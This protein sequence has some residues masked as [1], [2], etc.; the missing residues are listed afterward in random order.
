MY[1]VVAAAGED[2]GLPPDEGAGFLEWKLEDDED[3]FSQPK[4]G[5]DAGE[6]SLLPK[7]G[8]EKR[9]AQLDHASRNPLLPQLQFDRESASRVYISP[10]QASVTDIGNFLASLEL[11]DYV[12]PFQE[13]EID[14][15]ALLEVSQQQLFDEVR[16]EQCSH[17]SLMP[18]PFADL[19]LLW[20]RWV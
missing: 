18:Q 13:H 15:D 5:S 3:I 17:Y 7:G 11:S 16:A 12:I 14:G 19:E 9:M 4:S 1:E 2:F 6:A 8:R 20:R 10:K